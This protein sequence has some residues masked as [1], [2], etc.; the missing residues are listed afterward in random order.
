MEFKQYIG[1]GDS[2]STD[3]YPG[4]GLGAISLFYKNN[5]QMHPRFA[6]KDLTSLYKSMS[7]YSLGRDG[8]TSQKVVE[9]QLPKLPSEDLSTLATITVGGNDIL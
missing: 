5:N 6:G 2:I 7:L 4:K 1:L 9:E 8:A 3:D